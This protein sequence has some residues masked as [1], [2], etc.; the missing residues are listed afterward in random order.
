V[1]P[2]EAE[3]GFV[4]K[5]ITKGG[6]TT[7]QFPS[8]TPA[9][10]RLHGISGKGK[11]LLPQPLETYTAG[12]VPNKNLAPRTNV[13]WEKLE[14]GVAVP[15]LWDRTI[16][17]YTLES[18]GPHVLTNPKKLQGGTAYQ[19]WGHLQ[20]DQPAGASGSDVISRYIKRTQDAAKE[21]QPFLITSAMG[22][23]GG[24]FSSM[25]YAPIIDVFRQNRGKIDNKLVAEL[26]NGIRNKLFNDS[27]KIMGEEKAKIYADKWPGMDN[28]DLDTILAKMA[29]PYRS[30]M[31]KV[32]DKAKYRKGDMP[33]ISALRF[34][35]TEPDLLHAPSLSTGYSVAKLDPRGIAMPSGHNDYDT[36]IRGLG[37]LG[38]AKTH[39]PW[40]M[41]WRD[42]AATRPA[43]ENFAH[44]QKAFLTQMPLQKIDARLVDAIKKHEENAVRRGNP[45]GND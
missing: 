41:F 16:G 28:P 17:G 6:S 42:F 5:F 12:F 43:G 18:F 23:E 44:T 33:D 2:D 3:A 31:A 21:G 13:D 1:T 30:T 27:K 36:A 26:D 29:G 34:A 8:G 37:Y 14:G 9:N 32:M 19:R 15:A 24:D 10:T 7:L 39:S 20:P 22:N 45:F 38:G 35:T 11:L 25:M 40:D 4:P